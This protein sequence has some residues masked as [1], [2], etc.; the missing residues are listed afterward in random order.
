MR[1]SA[2]PA[3][4]GGTVP[5]ISFFLSSGRRHT[6]CSR[7]WSSDVCSSDLG[8]DRWGRASHQDRT[9]LAAHLSRRRDRKSV[10]EGKRVDLGGRRVLKK[11][12]HRNA[13]L[14]YHVTLSARTST[15]EPG[16]THD[17]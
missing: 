16:E 2:C 13:D 15:E 12:K 9:R 7:D 10:V 1:R 6:R 17:S 14:E 8:K 4:R 5:P 3:T 11:K